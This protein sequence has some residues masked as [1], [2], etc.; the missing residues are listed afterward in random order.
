MR[1]TKACISEDSEKTEMPTSMEKV[2]EGRLRSVGWRLSCL[3]MWG[4]FGEMH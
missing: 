2:F 1:T 4:S 3:T